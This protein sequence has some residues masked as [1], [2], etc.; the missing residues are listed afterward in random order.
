MAV[1]GL[2]WYPSRVWQQQSPGRSLAN[3]LSLLESHSSRLRLQ[4]E[5]G[6]L[7]QL[8]AGGCWWPAWP[9]SWPWPPLPHTHRTASAGRP[10]SISQTWNYIDFRAFKTRIS[11]PK[12]FHGFG[13]GLLCKFS[14]TRTALV[15]L[16]QE[17]ID[18]NQPNFFSCRFFSQDL[19]GIVTNQVQF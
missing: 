4:L 15:L 2:S 9:A 3:P 11:V 18:L 8:L 6:C 1:L 16:E 7:V 5:K 13:G 17:F 10:A 14:S 19:A 12:K